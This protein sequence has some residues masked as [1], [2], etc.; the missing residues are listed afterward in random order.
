MPIQS[1]VACYNRRVQRRAGIYIHIPFCERKCTYCNFN[2]TDFFEVLARRYISAVSR[3]L[4]Y[5]GERLT[6][7]LGDRA[8]VDTIYFGGGTPSIVDAAQLAELVRSCRAAFDVDRDAEVTIEIN[9]ASLSRT[10]ADGWLKAG[11]NRAS[12]GVQ[13]FLDSELVSLSRTHT[14]GNARC[15]I[16]V[17]RAA[18]FENISLDLIAGL[19]DQSLADWELNLREALAFRPDHLS[20]YLLEVKEG[21]Q[22]YGQ[23]KRGLRPVPDDD[24]AAEMYRMICDATQAAGYEH[25]EIS[26][27][28]RGCECEAA[29][30]VSPFRSKHN[31]KYWTGAPF[32]GIGCGAHSYDG[33]A[34]W[35]N[36]LKTETYIERITESRN[37]IADRSELSEADRAAEALFMGLRLNEGVSLAE[38]HAEYGVDVIERYGAELPRLA[39]A[40]LIEMAGGRLAL[41]A[42]GRLLSNEVFV[43]F[44]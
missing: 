17:L 5:W 1:E 32:Y 44:V 38:F 36:V 8:A 41:T 31:L 14:A 37:A 23:I 7:Q 10:K 19:P 22:L 11:I 30:P 20:L 35:V 43:S 39:D 6:E 16:D 40:G 2:T 34:R 13:S 12:V 33:F 27:F 3:E 24:L 42:A 15:T 18:G 9:P 29:K 25:Y 26:N 21:T 4:G 28:A